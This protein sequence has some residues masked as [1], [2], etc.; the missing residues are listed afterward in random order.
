MP[1][2]L[3]RDQIAECP[4]CSAKVLASSLQKDGR[5]VELLVCPTC[6]DPPQPQE[7]PFIPLD[8]EGKARFPIAPEQ[9]P[10]NENPVL[11][12]GGEDAPIP[13]TWTTGDTWKY[14]IVGHMLYRATGEDGTFSLIFDGDYT[15]G[16]APDYAPSYVLAHDD[17]TVDAG[18]IYRY[19]VDAVTDQGRHLPSN[20]VQVTPEIIVDCAIYS[21]ND[22]MEVPPAVITQALTS[23][24]GVDIE[25]VPLDD[26]NTNRLLIAPLYFEGLLDAEIFITDVTYGNVAV[27]Y[28]AN[29]NDSFH[30]SLIVASLIDIN[31]VEDAILRVSF[32]SVGGM[33]GTVKVQPLWFG[34]VAE[35][36]YTKF[37]TAA[38][39]TDAPNTAAYESILL[40]SSFWTAFNVTVDAEVVEPSL[41]GT[42]TEPDW[43]EVDLRFDG[44]NAAIARSFYYI[45]AGTSGTEGDIEWTYT[46]SIGQRAAAGIV[47]ISL[48][49]VEE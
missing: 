47:A 2:S 33:S 26:G 48:C 8:I 22:E 45:G 21:I 18:T 40:F 41:V 20:V 5:L 28:W 37:A 15:P 35:L 46:G 1:K 39:V 10:A 24:A 42:Y 16:S 36:I 19:R 30:A 27:D 9:L 4:R 31:E 3:G 17:D 34:N 44:E 38:L 7:S 6:W 23:R 32:S 12:L 11:T 14:I 49:D 29:D 25:L 13:L 43:P